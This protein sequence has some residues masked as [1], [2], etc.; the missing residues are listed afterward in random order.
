MKKLLIATTVI[1][2]AGACKKNDNGN[3]P[4]PD[5]QCGDHQS[6]PLY[7]ESNGNCYLLNS[8]GEKEYVEKHEC[9]C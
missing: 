2:L 7:R 4:G 5:V 6:Q 1:L 3:N 8:N 9:D